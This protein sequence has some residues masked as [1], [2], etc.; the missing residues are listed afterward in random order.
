MLSCGRSCARCKRTVSKENHA[1]HWF[2]QFEH[3]PVYSS[4]KL[5]AHTVFVL[6][7]KNMDLFSVNYTN[8]KK[9]KKPTKEVSKLDEK[10]EE[11]ITLVHSVHRTVGLNIC[12]SEITAHWFTCRCQLMALGCLFSFEFMAFLHTW[13]MCAL[14][15]S[16]ARN[17]LRFHPKQVYNVKI[18]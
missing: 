7:L 8:S 4:K 3:L 11:V 10:A 15:T 6:S 2:L 5:V 12:N 9:K 18:S 1:A 16:G 13:S 17:W 14:D